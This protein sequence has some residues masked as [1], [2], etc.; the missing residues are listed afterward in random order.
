MGVASII[1]WALAHLSYWVV[2]LLMVMENSVVPLPAELIV[3]P[4][5]YNAAN[6]KMSVV[7]LIVVSTAGSTVGAII[8]YYLSLWIGRPAI[9]KFAD[10]RWGKLPF[11]SR[12]KIE[13]AEELFRRNGKIST[14]IGR[15][16]PAGRQFISIPAGLARMDIGS[17]IFYTTFG[18]AIWNS[19]LVGLGYYLAYLLPED[20]IAAELEKYGMQLNVAF[21]VI[22][23]V[24][25]SWHFV[26][27][28]M[29][30]K[31]H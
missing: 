26:R 14:F 1:E 9:Y 6:G 4:A 10:S 29:H 15:L 16:L 11:L 12:G 31:R 30:K 20:Q 24:A 25:V 18:S 28:R 7:L 13:K 27:R 17:F 21:V 8:N 3:T 23:V 19:F 22:V 5:A 2:F